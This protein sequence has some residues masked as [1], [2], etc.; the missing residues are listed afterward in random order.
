ME[1]VQRKAL[2]AYLELDYKVHEKFPT[3]HFLK[4]CKDQEAAIF[5]MGHKPTT[6]DEA[7]D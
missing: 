5:A 6:L 7:Y 1:R 4:A 3:G 2:Q